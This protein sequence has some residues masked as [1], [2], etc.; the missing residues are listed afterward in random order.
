MRV[1]SSASGVRQRREDRAEPPGQHRL[2]RA[3][4]SAEQ[5]VVP[6]RG[7]DLERLARER[8]PAD[9]GE[10]D[11]L[12]VDQARTAGRRRHRRRRRI[13]V[14][15]RLLALQAGAQ[16]AERARRAHPHVADERGL[17]RVRRSG[18]SPPPRP[19]GR[20]RR[21]ARAC[22]APA[23]PCRRARARRARRRRR[24]HPRAARRWRRAPRA[25]PRARGRSRSCARRRARGS[26]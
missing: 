16:L 7:G 21:R 12:V 8:E 22:P 13:P 4:R 23:A 3:R 18:R 20:A 25:R 5:E 19:R 2:A 17:G 9:V 15:P 10:V 6:T 26:R 1:T 14:G 11:H 24:A